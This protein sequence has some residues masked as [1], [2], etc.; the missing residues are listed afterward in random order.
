GA[1]EED[2]NVNDYASGGDPNKYN[3]PGQEGNNKPKG[4][5]TTRIPGKPHKSKSQQGA[6]LVMAAHDQEPKKTTEAKAS[7]S[8]STPGGVS[9]GTTRI[10]GKPH[11]SKSQEGVELVIPAHDQEPMKTTEAKASGSRSTP[12][13]R[14]CSLDDDDD[15]DMNSIIG[16]CELNFNPNNVTEYLDLYDVKNTN[17]VRYSDKK[18]DCYT[19]ST[20][21]PTLCHLISIVPQE[22]IA[23]M[24]KVLFCIAVLIATVTMILAAS[25][26]AISSN[27]EKA[28]LAASTKIFGQ[29]LAVLYRPA[30]SKISANVG[31]ACTF[32]NYTEPD[33][34]MRQ[35]DALKAHMVCYK[36]NKCG[37][38]DANKIFAELRDT[39]PQPARQLIEE[40]LDEFRRF[41]FSFG[42]DFDQTA[43]ECRLR[44][45]SICVYRE[46]N[47]A[48]LPKDLSDSLNS[49]KCAT[50]LRCKA[51]K[52]IGNWPPELGEC[53]GVIGLISYSM[54]LMFGLAFAM[55][56]LS[57]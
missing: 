18:Y 22:T 27:D 32:K 10:P 53:S 38:T 55:T 25:S 39:I 30:D 35:C 46:T 52:D 56:Q 40:S 4:P 14:S 36:D 1:K 45:K 13:L 43:Q 5:G 8:R 12:D 50:D 17:Q 42:Q 24:G 31:E 20:R 48:G 47:F 26:P 37:C 41:G 19:G 9:G 57:F 54:T 11:K 6:E 28:P 34:I 16:S 44:E 21:C 51:V 3:I 2:Y 29:L 23:I 15:D 33:A 7:G 49:L